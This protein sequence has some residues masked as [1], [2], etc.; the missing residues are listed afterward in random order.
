MWANY[1]D[2]LSRIDE[3]PSWFDENAVPRFV[4]FEPI[5]LANI[6]AREC[7]LLLI[8]CQSCRT[9]FQVAMSGGGALQNEIRDNEIH[10]G[11]PPNTGCCD[12]GA[13]MNSVPLRVLEYWR[14]PDVF[15]WVR[16]P[17]LEVAIDCSWA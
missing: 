6:Y 2:I 17:A 8:R 7:M 13:S 1:H 16:D 4:Q 9:E 15:S 12:V 14:Q 5:R 10:F 3:P 11:D